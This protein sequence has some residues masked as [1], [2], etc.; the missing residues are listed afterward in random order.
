MRKLE[1][2]NVDRLKLIDKAIARCETKR[3]VATEL[4]PILVD[5]IEHGTNLYGISLVHIADWLVE[6]GLEL[7]V[8]SQ[9]G[10]ITKLDDLKTAAQTALDNFNQ[11]PRY[12]AFAKFIAN[13]LNRLLTRW[14]KGVL[15]NE[16]V[17][18]VLDRGAVIALIKQWRY[19]ALNTSLVSLIDEACVVRAQGMYIDWEK[20]KVSEEVSDELHRLIQENI[21]NYIV[22][23]PQT[24]ALSRRVARNQHVILIG[25]LKSGRLNEE[26]THEVLKS[27][28]TELL[29]NIGAKVYAKDSEIL[30]IIA[31]MFGGVAIGINDYIP[32]INLCIGHWQHNVENA[33]T[34]EIERL[35][36]QKLEVDLKQGLLPTEVAVQ[37]QEKAIGMLIH[38]TKHSSDEAISGVLQSFVVREL[39]TL[40]E[41]DMAPIA[42]KALLDETFTALLGQWKKDE[43]DV[44]QASDISSTI[45][46]DLHGYYTDLH[47]K[48]YNHELKAEVGELRAEVAHLIA[49]SNQTQN[50]MERLSAQ[51]ETLRTGMQA[52]PAQNPGNATGP[53]SYSI[54]GK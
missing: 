30:R 33:V 27:V 28:R 37:L 46:R 19:E 48:V 22:T 49:Q 14:D 47:D 10:A 18:T 38:E 52:R 51:L 7:E 3:A 8:L 35:I 1:T 4:M 5:A 11:S 44:H 16:V 31:G 25:E 29:N 23:E 40:V 41:S 9:A 45:N 34:I 50:L 24:S 32:T 43:L 26:Y 2:F 20:N 12:R 6:G 17:S 53:T 36:T 39:A 54:F 15:M 21:Q 13:G 42:Q